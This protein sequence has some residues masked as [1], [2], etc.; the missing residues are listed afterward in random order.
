LSSEEDQ[1]INQA[2]FKTI[3]SNSIESARPTKGTLIDVNSSMYL[4][5]LFIAALNTSLRQGE[6][7]SLTWNDIDFDKCYIDVNK[8]AKNASNATRKG[9]SP[10]KIILLPLKLEI[11]LERL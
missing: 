7:F 4:E 5:I 1:S 6:L 8:T 9:R 10:S 11:A 3:L 2:R